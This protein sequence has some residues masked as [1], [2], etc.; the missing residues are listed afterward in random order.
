MKILIVDD[1]VALGN[2]I[3]MTLEQAGH[4]IEKAT[5]GAEGL[6]RSSEGFD[7]VLSDW[8]MPGQYNGFQMLTEILRNNPNQR[9]IMMSG[10]WDNKPPE[11]VPLL[12]K[13]FSVRE[14]LLSPDSCYYLS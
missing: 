12:A 2:L 6:S 4:E 1:D 5:S 11:G 10:K 14:L 8:D 9:A 13:P 3:A 7:L